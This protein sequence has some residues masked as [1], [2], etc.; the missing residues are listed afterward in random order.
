LRSHNVAVITACTARGRRG[1]TAPIGDMVLIPVSFGETPML[2]SRRVPICEAPS[3]VDLAVDGKGNVLEARALSEV[4]MLDRAAVEH[5][6]NWKFHPSQ[7][8]RRRAAFVY[9]FAFDSQNCW[10]KQQQAFCR[11]ADQYYRLSSCHAT[12]QPQR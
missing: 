10:P 8:A 12:V 4:P 3:V 7:K 9:E 2:S 1:A 5:A 6:R 11:V